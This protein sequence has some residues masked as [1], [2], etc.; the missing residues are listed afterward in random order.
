MKNSA[1][2]GNLTVSSKQNYIVYGSVRGLVSEH[3]TQSGAERS[4]AKDRNGCSSLGGGA[5]SD[6]SVYQ[7][8]DGGWEV[9]EEAYAE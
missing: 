3:R 4:A 6:V 8:T 5:Y 2:I 1:Y 7:W 9:C